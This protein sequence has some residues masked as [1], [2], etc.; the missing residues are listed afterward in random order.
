MVGTI[1]GEEGEEE[2]EED[3]IFEVEASICFKSAKYPPLLP[4]FRELS[5][6]C[7]LSSGFTCWLLEESDVTGRRSSCSVL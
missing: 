6:W 4:P 5:S 1:K 3:N 2:N 7:R